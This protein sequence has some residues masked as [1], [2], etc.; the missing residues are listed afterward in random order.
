MEEGATGLHRND[1]KKEEKI[2]AGRI[3]DAAIHALL[4]EVAATPKPG[5]VDRCDNGAHSDMDFFTFMASVAVLR[6]AF[7]HFAEIGAKTRNIKAYNAFR[8]LQHAGLEAE[9]KMFAATNGVN[10]HKGAIFSLGVVCGATGRMSRDEDK[11]PEA[12]CAVAAALCAGIC[13]EAYVTLAEAA[14]TRALTKGERVFLA[15]GIRG[16][17]GE[18]EGGFPSVLH[19]GLPAYREMKKNGAPE[20]D[21]LVQTLLHLM[22][23][24]HDTNVI[25]RH[26]LETSHYVQARAADALSVGGITTPEGR[27]AVDEMDRDFTRKNISPGG[28]A[29]LLAVT[30]FL[31]SL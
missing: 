29:D 8:R 6:N 25:S 26:D 15:H 27:R 10:T 23:S 4:L 30:V 14:K 12:I 13:N 3:G 19:V 2:L 16:V 28:V 31:D 11:N 22:S 24:V 1:E 20:N 18:A 21:A 5:L 9:G 7:E 17:R